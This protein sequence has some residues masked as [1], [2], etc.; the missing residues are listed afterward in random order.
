M[1]DDAGATW[2][3]A[4]GL[5]TSF[6]PVLGDA[7]DGSGPPLGAVAPDGSWWVLGTRSAGPLSVATSTDH[8]AHWR[9]AATR[10]LTGV[11]LR[12]IAR[13]ARA[14]WALVRDGADVRLYATGDRGDT[15]VPV[16]PGQA[17]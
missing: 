14:A 15:W 12:L 3:A 13:S 17:R 2:R 1:S 11:P 16:N 8:G 7:H 4:G 6:T 9:T 5:A 10:G